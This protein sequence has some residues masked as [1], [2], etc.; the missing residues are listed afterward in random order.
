M[1]GE[2]LS[3]SQNHPELILLQ[4]DDDNERV[5]TTTTLFDYND[6]HHDRNRSNGIK[7]TI[8]DSNHDDADYDDKYDYS[9]YEHK[10]EDAMHFQYYDCDEYEEEYE[11]IDSN[12]HVHEGHIRE[13]DE[14]LYDCNDECEVVYAEEERSPFLLWNTMES[15]TSCRSQEKC[16]VDE[17]QETVIEVAQRTTTQTRRSIHNASNKRKSVDHCTD[18][19]RRYQNFFDSSVDNVNECSEKDNLFASVMN[20]YMND[21]CDSK[22]IV[23]SYDG[24]DA[25]NDKKIEKIQSQQMSQNMKAQ[26]NLPQLDDQF[27]NVLVTNITKNRISHNE[28]HL[29][30]AKL[31]S[32]PPSPIQQS[33]ILQRARK[34]KGGIQSENALSSQGS[35]SHPKFGTDKYR[36]NKI[37]MQSSKSI[38]GTRPSH[39]NKSERSRSQSAQVRRALLVNATKTQTARNSLHDSQYSQAYTPKMSLMMSQT[40]MTTSK[41]NEDV[42]VRS[43]S[44][45]LPFQRKFSVKVENSVSQVSDFSYQIL[46]YRFSLYYIM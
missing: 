45:K 44:F 5:T 20:E 33:A 21:D 37:S 3:Q 39:W 6:I 13:D 1:T 27:S 24:V 31:Q 8:N 7:F 2:P 28:K 46:V 41:W 11:I 25:S 38:V 43:M 14:E 26:N 12:D 23:D 22:V 19:V 4:D 36:F 15:R 30:R 9:S 34:L 16:D 40:D 35:L 29:L 10:H 17:E 42:D 32:R 18:A